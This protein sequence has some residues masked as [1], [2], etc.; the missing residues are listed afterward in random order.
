[1]K[2]CYQDD[3]CPQLGLG[4]GLEEDSCVGS[5][6]AG[7]KESRGGNKTM[8]ILPADPGLFLSQTRKAAQAGSTGGSASGGSWLNPLDLWR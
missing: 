6:T 7:K 3:P 5:P 8:L 2:P 4:L 1:M